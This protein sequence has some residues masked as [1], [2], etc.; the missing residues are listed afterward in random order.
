MLLSSVATIVLAAWVEADD[1]PRPCFDFD[2]TVGEPLRPSIPM[3]LGRDNSVFGTYPSGVDWASTRARLAMPI[4][5]L[6]A[7]SST[8]ATTRT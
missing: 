2:T 1:P 6:Y 3:V 5:V 8:T 4:S 7:G